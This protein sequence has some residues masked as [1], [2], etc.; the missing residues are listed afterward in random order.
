MYAIKALAE[1]DA[2]SVQ[3]KRALKWIVESAAMTYEETFRP[4]T[5]AS[6]YVQGRRS[7]GLA[8]VKM[9]NL[10]SGIF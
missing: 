2:D 4:D 5:N 10:K 3:Q 9:I 8:I 7:V 1:G 6:I